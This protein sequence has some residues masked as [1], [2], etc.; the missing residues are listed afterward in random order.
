MERRLAGIVPYKAVFF[1][2]TAMVSETAEGLGSSQI[3]KLF[4][5]TTDLEGGT[6][7]LRHYATATV[8]QDLD[9]G[10]EGILRVA[11]KTCRYEIRQAEK[12]SSRIEIRRTDPQASLDFIV[13]YNELARSKP[14][15][16]T[17]KNRVFGRYRKH[18]DTFVL[19]LDEKPMCGHMVLRDPDSARVR[20]LYSASRRFDNKE[21]AR[22]CGNLNRLLHLHEMRLYGEER[23]D[24]YD[25]GGIR[26]D[27]SDGIARFK[28][29]FG[30]RVVREHTYLCTGRPWLAHVMLGLIETL[31]VRG[32]HWRSL[33][34]NSAAAASGEPVRKPG[35][36]FGRLSRDHRR[37][38]LERKDD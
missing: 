33:I 5:T 13:L 17:V 10:P 12:L 34:A 35:D 15:V 32:R 14:E 3:A 29:S 23:F 1:P 37:P 36:S 6:C 38:A 26:E 31:S 9:D 22:L 4:W 20:L 28:L 18:T 27:G 7:L 8:C 19:Y 25:F 21:T 16:S 2:T 30:G 24:T 11:S